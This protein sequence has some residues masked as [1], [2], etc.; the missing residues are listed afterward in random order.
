M[1]GRTH[2][3][4]GAS[5]SHPK[6]ENKVT[7]KQIV[8]RAADATAIVL[9]SFLHDYQSR[10]ERLTEQAQAKVT[11]TEK[12][13][14]QEFTEYCIENGIDIKSPAAAVRYFIVTGLDAFDA[15]RRATP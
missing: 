1:P 3:E 5:P 14:L 11:P 7:T 4:G 10:G 15:E 6:L 2:H 12:E 8:R 13:R 9:G